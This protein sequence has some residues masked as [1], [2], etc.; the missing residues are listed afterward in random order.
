MLPKSCNYFLSFFRNSVFVNIDTLQ[1][2]AHSPVHS[3]YGSGGNAI[4][5]WLSP[6]GKNETRRKLKIV[7]IMVRKNAYANITRLRV[8]MYDHDRGQHGVNYFGASAFRLRTIRR[9]FRRRFNWNHRQAIFCPSLRHH[10]VHT[11]G[12]LAAE[13]RVLSVS[14]VT[15]DVRKSRNI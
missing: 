12:I 11:Y 4:F 13:T 14:L 2:K 10:I 8:R 6:R 5:V 9:A 7:C 1:T 15:Q 3:S